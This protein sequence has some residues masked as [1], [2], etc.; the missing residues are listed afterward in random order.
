M[1][2]PPVL[3]KPLIGMRTIKTVIAVF[4]SA[5]FMQHVLHQTPFFAC[6]GAV[7]AMESSVHSSLRAALIRNLGTVIGG[8]VGIAI[9]SFTESPLL[10]SLG[11][12]PLILL[13][14]LLNRKESIVPG[15]IVY[16]AVAYLNTMDQAW[17]YGLRRI[18]GTFIGTLIGLGVNL[19]LFRPKQPP[20]PPAEQNNGPSPVSPDAHTDAKP[21]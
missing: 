20:A 18:L 3:R 2:P 9:A 7:V 10:I 8:A 15:A 1:E 12:I 19:L 17:V 6:I 13:S 16:F 4:L 5:L 11:M 14:N 21:L